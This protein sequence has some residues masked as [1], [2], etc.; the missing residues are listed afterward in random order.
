MLRAELAG[1]PYVKANFN[2]EVQAATGRSHGAVEYK[3]ENI[4]AVLREIGLPYIPGYKPAPNLQDALRTEVKRFLSHNPEIPCPPE[5]MPAPDL[6]PSVQLVEVEPPVMPPPGAGGRGRT[7]V[8]VDYLEREARNR[9]VGLKGELLVVEH[10]RAW[11][12]EHD[13]PD[14]AELEVHVPSTLG[15][16][17]GYDVS[18]FLLD[19]S[20]H[21]IEV[22]TTRRSITEPFFLSASE[23][24]HAR[25]HPEAYSIYRI[26]DLGPNPGFYKL[27]GDMD[28]ILDLTP[29]S[30]Q[31]RVKAP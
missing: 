3:F 16:G 22:K 27:T 5:D 25:E 15:D 17:A 12:S 10:E 8:G 9:D 18:S 4:S 24:C 6:P 14:P 28:D 7:A 30:Y 20:P 26:F 19:E 31:A 1:Q 2:R 23:L 11:L 13:R 21:H 29:V